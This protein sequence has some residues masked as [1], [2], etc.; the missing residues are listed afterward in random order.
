MPVVFRALQYDS[1]SSAKTTYM[2]DLDNQIANYKGENTSSQQAARAEALAR[3]AAQ[4][5]I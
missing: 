1:L 5:G 3:R 4:Y 2:T